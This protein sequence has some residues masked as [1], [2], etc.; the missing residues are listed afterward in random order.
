M[1]VMVLAGG[2][3]SSQNF[4][5]KTVRIV[6]ATPAGGADFVARVIENDPVKDFSPITLVA[7]HA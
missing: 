7:R 3:A 6:A 5:N 1:S 2:M 4:P